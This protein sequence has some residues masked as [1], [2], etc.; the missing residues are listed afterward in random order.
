RE[1]APRAI[2]SM[3]RRSQP[4]DKQ[5]CVG[6]AEPR[7]AAS[8]I[9]PLAVRPPLLAR[10]LF[11]VFHQPR[12]LA[13]GTDFLRDHAQGRFALHLRPLRAAAISTAWFCFA[14]FR[15]YS[16][17]TVPCSPSSRFTSA[18]RSFFFASSLR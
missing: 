5:L 9:F 6:I 8:P 14:S 3:R 12:A 4:Q 17:V 10:H 18:S 13:A 16:S 2:C 1:Y 15:P 7:H 11:P